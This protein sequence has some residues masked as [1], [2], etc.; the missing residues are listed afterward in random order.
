M[1]TYLDPGPQAFDA[2]IQRADV[3]GA[4][5]YV[6]FPGDVAVLFGAR[7]RVPVRARFDGVDYRGSL[8]TYGGPHIVGVLKDVQARIGKGPGDTVHVELEL[9]TTERVVELADDVLRALTAAGAHEAFR[10]LSYSR[11]REYAQWI[12]AA[13][14]PETRERRIAETAGRAGKGR[15]LK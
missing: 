15:P 2:V 3:A 1:P 5:A 9:D 10:A 11:Q 8:V 12:E 6:E 7:G 4:G 13:K 14:R